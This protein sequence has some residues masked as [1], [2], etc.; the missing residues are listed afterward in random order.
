M[1]AEIHFIENEGGSPHVSFRLGA[2]ELF[3]WEKV[4]RAMSYCLTEFVIPDVRLA[5]GPDRLCL[6]L[7][8]TFDNAGLTWPHS[9]CLDWRQRSESWYIFRSLLTDMRQ[10]G[11]LGMLHELTRDIRNRDNGRIFV[12]WTGDSPSG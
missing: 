6:R 9:G 5:D 11:R 10:N 3:R 12:C 7:Y 4:F 1:A 8:S 2:D